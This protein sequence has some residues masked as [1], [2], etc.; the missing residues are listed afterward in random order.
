MKRKEDEMELRNGQYVL[1]VNRNGIVRLFV[2]R[3]LEYL[4]EIENAPQDFDGTCHRTFGHFIEAEAAK[5]GLVARV[6]NS[7]WFV[8][9]ILAS[10]G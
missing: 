9:D 2:F 6:Q 10:S 3:N 1:C 7:V 8:F 5:Y 4:G